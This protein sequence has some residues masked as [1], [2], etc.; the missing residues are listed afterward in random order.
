MVRDV[1]QAKHM[2]RLTGSMGIGHVRYPT[3]GGT[4]A[5]EVQPFYSNVPFGVSLAHNG[6]LNNN[7]TL[8]RTLLEENHRRVNTSSDSE[9]LLN[10]FAAEL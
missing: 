6:N 8:I 3:A 2:M 5:A 7:E 4:N 9:A 1:F 10:V